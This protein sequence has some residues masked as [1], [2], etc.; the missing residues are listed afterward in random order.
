[1]HTLSRILLSLSL[2][3]ALGCLT[4]CSDTPS[5]KPDPTQS[6]EMKD[7]MNKMQGS[8]QQFGTPG[9]KGPGAKKK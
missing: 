9:T 2:L 6:A 5:G 1:M 7:M 3:F 8:P 4:S